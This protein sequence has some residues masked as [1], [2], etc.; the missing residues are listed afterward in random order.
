MLFAVLVGSFFIIFDALAGGYWLFGASIVHECTVRI[1]SLY[2]IT[3][4]VFVCIFKTHKKTWT[5]LEPQITDGNFESG[6]K[7][8]QQLLYERAHGLDCQS[9]QARNPGS[10]EK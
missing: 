7:E 5:V 9:K 1:S 6:K 2:C 3:F 4:A 8:M 10:F